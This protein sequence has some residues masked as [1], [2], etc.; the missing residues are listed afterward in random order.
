VTRSKAELLRLEDE[1]YAEVHELLGALTPQQ[2]AEPGLEG[3]W[4]AK[5][6]I[7]HLASWCSEAARHIEQIR[8]GTYD[9]TRADERAIDRDIDAINRRFHDANRELS[10][11]DV[12]A[13]LAASRFRMLEELDLIPEV[14]KT[15]AGWFHASGPGH[16][17]EHLPRL[18]E[19]V[20]GLRDG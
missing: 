17:D 4:S 6:L 20:A 9:L 2:L 12:K 15:C 7:A 16:Y 5:D 8:L 13:E 3:D 14:T 10:L 18:R 1:G 11:G 19:W